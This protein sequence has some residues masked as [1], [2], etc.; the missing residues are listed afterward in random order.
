MTGDSAPRR[1]NGFAL[2][3][4]LGWL[5]DFSAFNLLTLAH[6]PVFAANLVGASLGVSFV[7]V[8]GRRFIFR[9]T[10]TRLSHA[11]ALY[12]LWNLVAILA[13]SF[14]VAAIAHLL[15][16]EAARQ[17]AARLPAIGPYWMVLVP[18]IAKMAFTPVTMYANFVVMGLIIERRLH[19]V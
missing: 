10:R 1:L 11:I 6:V 7:F 12:A 4:G 14:C 8:T 5:I 18:P 17:L 9:D 15:G 19:F 3:S 13:A 2:L 16:T